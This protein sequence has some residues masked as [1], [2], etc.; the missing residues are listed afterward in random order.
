M[1]ET[2]QDAEPSCETEELSREEGAA[3]LDK[4]AQHRLGISGAEFLARWDD[5]FYDDADD[6]AV[7]EVAMLIPFT[8]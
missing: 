8:R 7:T 5:D 2:R 3:M 6:P 1:P 4:A